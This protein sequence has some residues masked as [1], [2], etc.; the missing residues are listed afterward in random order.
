MFFADVM[1]QICNANLLK[2]QKKRMEDFFQLIFLPKLISY[3]KWNLPSARE[4]WQ[5]TEKKR[6][7]KKTEK[8]RER[9]AGEKVREKKTENRWRGIN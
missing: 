5:D 7:R 8:V 4:R 2:R 3:L 1:S 6:E 9:K